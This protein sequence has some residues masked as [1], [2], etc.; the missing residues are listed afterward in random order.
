VNATLYPNP[1]SQSA[2]L[3]LAGFQLPAP[4]LRLIIYDIM[5]KEVRRQTTNDN[6]RFTIERGNLMN[7]MY[8]YSVLNEQKTIARG[9][10]IVGE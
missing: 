4:G 5:G 7:G 9:K 8:F 1:F 6:D 2:T 10:M 3:A